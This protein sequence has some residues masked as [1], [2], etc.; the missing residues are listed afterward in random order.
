MI[1]REKKTMNKMNLN[2]LSREELAR[3]IIDHRETEAGI[4][5]RRIYIR[6]LAEKA[7]TCGVEFY[8]KIP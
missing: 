2:S 8:K 6:R 4:E 3:F 5:A 7:K 1:Y